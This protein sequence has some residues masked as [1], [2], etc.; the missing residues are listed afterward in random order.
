VGNTG[1]S[2]LINTIQER[3]KE[4]KVLV[5]TEIARSLFHLIQKDN[6]SNFQECIFWS[7]KERFEQIQDEKHLYD[8]IITDRTRID[9]LAYLNFNMIKGK[10]KT[11]VA[12]YDL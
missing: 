10:I 12:Q 9:Q 3:T 4:Y 5:L 2:T 7:E 11:P 6:L 1:K 8:L